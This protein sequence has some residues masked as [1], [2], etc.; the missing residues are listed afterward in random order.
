MNTL[1]EEQ[2]IKLMAISAV[3]VHY[4]NDRQSPIEI[5][6]DMLGVDETIA[7][8]WMERRRHMWD[9]PAIMEQFENIIKE[10]YH[11]S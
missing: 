5:A 2:L 10:R 3:Y 8:A 9:D 7:G 11:A 6:A 1:T 4:W